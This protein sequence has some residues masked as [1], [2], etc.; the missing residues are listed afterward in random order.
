MLNQSLSTKQADNSISEQ[1]VPVSMD[2]SQMQGGKVEPQDDFEDLAESKEVIE[3]RIFK[4]RLQ[5][6]DLVIQQQQL[7]NAQKTLMNDL[8]QLQG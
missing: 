2:H 5:L 3:D 8:N 7:R 1:G 6:I 4:I